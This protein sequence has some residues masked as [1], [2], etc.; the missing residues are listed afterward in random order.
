[1]NTLATSQ[2]LSPIKHKR[3]FSRHLDIERQPAR[4]TSIANN[5]CLEKTPMRR[6]KTNSG[7]FKISVS[8]A[9]NFLGK[10]SQ[11]SFLKSSKI[12]RKSS[13][14]DFRII[15]RQVSSKKFSI[16]S[17]NP[18]HSSLRNFLNVPQKISG[19]EKKKEEGKFTFTSS[20]N[21]SPCIKRNSFYVSRTLTESSK[22]RRAR[23]SHSIK[24]VL[25]KSRPTRKTSLERYPALE[26][27][28]GSETDENG[29][30][31]QKGLMSLDRY[32]RAK[33]IEIS[34]KGIS[35]FFDDVKSESKKTLDR[36]INE[37]FQSRNF[38]EDRIRKSKRRVGRRQLFF[39]DIK[40]LRKIFDMQ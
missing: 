26:E 21:D 32:C 20:Q 13:L 17:T 27:S 5:F 18:Q 11:S 2:T 19:S 4:K 3:V 15:K 14:G 28:E 7:E 30:P 24:I 29:S 36:E 39:P 23:S 22:R 35:G 1:M 25:V 16:L 38:L 40:R 12:A 10:N 6:P 8:T 31:S 34:Q 33:D 37:L 9:S